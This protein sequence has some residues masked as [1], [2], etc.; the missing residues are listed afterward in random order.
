MWTA[1][2]CASFPVPGRGA[3]NGSRK[4]RGAFAFHFFVIYFGMPYPADKLD[5]IAIPDFASG[6]METSDLYVRET[7]LLLGKRARR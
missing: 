2:P 3:A 7:A 4:R 6:A 1:Y 5:H